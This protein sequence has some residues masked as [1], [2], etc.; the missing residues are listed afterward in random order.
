MGK[1]LHEKVS[2]LVDTKDLTPEHAQQGVEELLQDQEAQAYW[3]RLHVSRAILQNELQEG[4]P[5]DIS[6]AVAAQ[7]ALEPE[8]TGAIPKET[9]VLQWLQQMKKPVANLAVAASVACVTVLGV[10]SYQDA[11]MPTD[12]EQMIQ[13]SSQPLLQTV[14]LGVVEN[15]VSYD[16]TAQRTTKTKK[17]TLSSQKQAAQ[18]AMAHKQI[19]FFI[20]DHQSQVQT[21]NNQDSKLQKQEGH[22]IED[23]PQEN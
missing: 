8:Y 22:K 9:K 21:L 10:W 2:F 1:T 17:D 6:Q 7:I 15:P 13:V 23:E 4:M 19:Q 16:A 20:H 5:I 12:T 11:S 18:Q 14:P 3:H